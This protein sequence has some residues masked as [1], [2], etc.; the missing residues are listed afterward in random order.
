MIYSPK[1]P[2][3]TAANEDFRVERQKKNQRFI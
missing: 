3:L 2:K 1:I